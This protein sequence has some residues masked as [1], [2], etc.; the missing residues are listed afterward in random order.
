MFETKNIFKLKYDL[1]MTEV[2]QAKKVVRKIIEIDEDMCTGCG[3]QVKVFEYEVE[4]GTWSS[5]KGRYMD[6]HSSRLIT[7]LANWAKYGTLPVQYIL[8]QHRFAS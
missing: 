3:R 2:K 4:V 5:S 6:H 7:L 8:K 1:N